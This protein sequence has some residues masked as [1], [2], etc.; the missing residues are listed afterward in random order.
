MPS[1]QYGPVGDGAMRHSGLPSS[2]VTGR[3][4]STMSAV[5]AVYQKICWA[6]LPW[7]GTGPAS[8]KVMPWASSGAYFSSQSTILVTANTEAGALVPPPRVTLAPTGRLSSST[9]MP[10]SST[11]LPKGTPGLPMPAMESQESWK[12]QPSDGSRRP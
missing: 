7:A 12:R 6:M 4:G 11:G 3:P 8:P 5:K 1:S 9:R 10:Q 2:S